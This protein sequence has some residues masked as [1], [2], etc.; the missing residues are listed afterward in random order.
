MPLILSIPKNRVDEI[1]HREVTRELRTLN[2]Y[3]LVAEKSPPNCKFPA[4]V[5]RDLD[6]DYKEMIL[7]KDYTIGQ[8][9][10]I[11]VKDIVANFPIRVLEYQG[12]HDN[13]YARPGGGPVFNLPLL[14]PIDHVRVALPGSFAL[15]LW[16]VEYDTWEGRIEWNDFELDQSMVTFVNR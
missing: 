1:I 13:P 7:H 14:G 16:E 3:Q 8:D 11:S 15:D 4:V 12:I 2:L 6:L 5:N 9:T 10:T